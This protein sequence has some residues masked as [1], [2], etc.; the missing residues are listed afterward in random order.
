[1]LAPAVYLWRCVDDRVAE[2]GATQQIDTL[3]FVAQLHEGDVPD[4][5]QRY[6]VRTGFFLSG[7]L[8]YARSEET[9][10]YEEALSKRRVRHSTDRRRLQRR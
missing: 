9:R 5:T 2:D 8:Q 7:C 1:M 10:P 3:R 4:A 6:F